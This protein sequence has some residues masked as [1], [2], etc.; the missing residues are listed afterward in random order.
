MALLSVNNYTPQ[1]PEKEE[2]AW[3]K[4]AKGLQIANTGFGIAVNWEQFQKLRAENE[5]RPQRLEHDLAKESNQQKFELEKQ[6]LGDVAHMERTKVAGQYGVD[7][8][9]VRVR[10]EPNLLPGSSPESAV[11]GLIPT[12]VV[13]PT[14]AEA[15][16]LRGVMGQAKDFSAGLK[17]Y[18]DLVEK[19]GSFE[20]FGEDAQRMKVLATDLQLKAKNPAFYELGVL[21]G[22]DLKMIEKL[23]GNPDSLSSMFTRD[24]TALAGLDQLAERVGSKVASDA[25]ARGYRLDSDTASLLLPKKKG[26]NSGAGGG[27]GWG[28]IQSAHATDPMIGGIMEKYGVSAAEAQTLLESRRRAK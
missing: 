15:E 24:K 2:S 10:G 9:R 23:I 21:S 12:G 8:A 19:N 14:K 3:D 7:A 26:G 17:E 6:R 20:A 22:P 1:K 27:G 4:I 16:K 28:D 18:R 11:P 13:A 5:E 25:N